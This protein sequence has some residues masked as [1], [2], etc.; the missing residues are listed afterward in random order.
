M[1]TTFD[2]PPKNSPHIHLVRAT[3]AENNAQTIANSTEW[4]GAL[5][6]PAYL[7]REEHLAQ[8]SL[9]RNGG[10]TAWMLVYH[11]PGSGSESRRVV[12]GCETIKKRA[13]VAKEGKGEVEEVVSF[14]VCSVFCPEGSRKRGYAGRMMEELGK[15]LDK[16]G[17]VFSV[18]FSDIGKV[19]FPGWML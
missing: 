6:L 11:P 8:Q 5:P 3:P 2:H 18:L 14:G 17:G 13:L 19:S 16:E 1:M 7:K 10:L 15:R 4:R 9:T 12:C